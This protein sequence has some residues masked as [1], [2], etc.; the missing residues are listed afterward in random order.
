MNKL[1]Y[2]GAVVV[3]VICALIGVPIDF[4]LFGLT[5]V[6]VALFHHHT[7]QVALTGLAVVTLYKLGFT[8][9]KT[10]PGL[11]GLGAA[12][13]ARVDH[14]HEPARPAAR[15]RAAFEPFRAQ[16]GARGAAA[17]PARRLERRLHAPR[18]GVRAVLVP[19]QHRRRARSAAPWRRGCSARRCISATSPP[20]SP[21]RTRAAPA[22]WWATPPRP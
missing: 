12:H 16:Q 5:L 8:G 22:A 21:R 11:G 1:L 6:G 2:G 18:H 9:F 19:G 7:L 20:S 4:V 13:G 17:L 15:F 10:G 3:G 14:P